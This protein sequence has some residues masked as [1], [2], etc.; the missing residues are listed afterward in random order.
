[1]SQ[2]VKDSHNKGKNSHDT[3]NFLTA[4]KK[5]N[6]HNKRNILAAGEKISQWGEGFLPG[7]KFW[8]WGKES[9]GQDRTSYDRRNTLT[10]REK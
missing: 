8:Q 5:K 7:E 4:K 10:T 3:S 1:M 2:P 9:S 6:C